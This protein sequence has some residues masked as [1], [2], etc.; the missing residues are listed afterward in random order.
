[1]TFRDLGLA[2][3]HYLYLEKYVML[4]RNVHALRHKPCAT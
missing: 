4:T 3:M 2:I 1:M